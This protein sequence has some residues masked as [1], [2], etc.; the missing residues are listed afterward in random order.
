MP[1]VL[2][3]DVP[4]FPEAAIVRARP[5]LLRILRSVLRIFVV[6][7]IACLP[8]LRLFIDR[9]LEVLLVR[10]V[11]IIT[12]S[13]WVAE[14]VDAL[15]VVRLWNVRLKAFAHFFCL[16]FLRVCMYE[17]LVLDLIPSWPTFFAGSDAVNFFCFA[18]FDDEIDE[19]TFV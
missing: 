15:R 11:F 12:H 7:V 9:R 18:V 19:L 2:T 10:F 8:T 13:E 6:T 16:P 17:V 4:L 3:P 14:V 5:V 1:S